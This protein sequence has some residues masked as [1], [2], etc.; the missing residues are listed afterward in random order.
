MALFR[1]IVAN[2]PVGRMQHYLTTIVRK[3]KRRDLT[4]EVPRVLDEQYEYAAPLWTG[5]GRL[6]PATL[7]GQV[8][9]ERLR[10]TGKLR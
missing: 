4:D 5:R 6:D 9:L 8:D 7:A 10:T 2:E 1:S 3:R